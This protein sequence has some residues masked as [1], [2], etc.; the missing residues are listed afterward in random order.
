MLRIFLHAVIAACLLIADGYGQSAEPPKLIAEGEWSKPVGDGNGYALRGRLVLCEKP[1]RG[2]LRDVAVYVELQDASDAV[3]HGMQIFCEMSRTDFRP[4]YKG[5]LVCEMR[6]KE[7]QLIPPTRSN[8]FGGATPATRWVMLPDDAT[9]RL[10]AS[11]YGIRRA[12][13]MSIMPSLR[14]LWVIADDDPKEYFLSGTFTVA[15]TDDRLEKEGGHIWRGTL[16]LP[17]M[18][19]KNTRP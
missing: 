19:I 14:S 16:V 7:N 13:A 6:D 15:P 8:A 1:G 12:K 11:P 5:G 4:E 10:R 3:G 18:R 17:P 9:I 2:E